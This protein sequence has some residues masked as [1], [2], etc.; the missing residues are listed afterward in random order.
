MK[1]AELE[2]LDEYYNIV[3]AWNV[4][5]DMEVKNIKAKTRTHN[6]YPHSIWD[7]EVRQVETYNLDEIL[8]DLYAAGWEYKCTYWEGG[9]AGSAHKVF[10]FIKK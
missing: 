7:D 4:T 3:K 6:I 1:Y 9:S 10:C 2:C 5:V 8:D